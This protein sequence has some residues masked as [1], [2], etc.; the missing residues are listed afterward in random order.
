LFYVDLHL[1]T[2]KPAAFSQALRGILGGGASPVE[3]SLIDSVCK[4]TG[5]DSSGVGTLEQAVER[6]LRRSR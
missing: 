2:S 3:S 5:V 4:S 1:I 6:A